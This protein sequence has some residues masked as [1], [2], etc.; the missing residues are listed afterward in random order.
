MEVVRGE[1]NQGD[2]KTITTPDLYV[3]DELA[4]VGHIY[5]VGD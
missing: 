3:P 1:A 2:S 4:Q 5:A